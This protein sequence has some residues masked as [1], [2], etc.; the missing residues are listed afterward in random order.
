MVSIRTSSGYNEVGKNMTVVD[1]G[2]DIIVFDCGLYLPAVIDLQEQERD[3]TPAMLK[4]AGALPDDSFLQKNRDKVRAFLITHAHLDH[5]GAVH[6]VAKNYPRAEIF[7]TPFTIEV[8]KTLMQDSKSVLRNKITR[9]N[10]DSSCFI[11]GRKKTYKADFINMTHSTIQSTIIA[12]HTDKGAIVYGNDY[13]LDNTPMM[14][15]PP[16]YPKM[17]NLAKQGVKALIVD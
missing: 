4:S 16:N 7:G 17:R 1:L 10:P 14:G 2:E 8:L 15:K 9:V 6:H 12:L 13:K 3:P 5:V 11:R